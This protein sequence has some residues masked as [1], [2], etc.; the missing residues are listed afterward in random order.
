MAYLINEECAKCGSCELECPNAAISEGDDIY[1]IDP[2]KCTECVGAFESSRC[3]EICPVASPVPDPAHPESR[4]E[5]LAK[6][7][8]LH[9]VG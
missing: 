5:L 3:A 7:R 2:E 1:I 6:Y 4:D 8:K 9:P